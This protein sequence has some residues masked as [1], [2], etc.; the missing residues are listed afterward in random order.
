[1]VAVAVIV[2]M[3]LDRTCSPRQALRLA[4]IPAGTLL[5]AAATPVGPQLYSSFGAIRAVSPYIQEWRIPTLNSPSV[6]AALTMGL[7]TVAIWVGRREPGSWVHISLLGLGFAWGA[8]HMRTVAVGAI[9]VAPV[10]AAALDSA[11]GRPRKLIGRLET[12]VV[13]AGAV[14]SLAISAGLAASGPRDPTGVPSGLSHEL[15]ALPSGTVVYNTD[16]LGGWIMWSHPNL[17]QTRDTRAELYGPARARDYL[18]AMQA[19][20]GWQEI[21]RRTQPGAAL[22]QGDK[23]LVAALRGE[24]W[25]LLGHD[26]GYVLLEPPRE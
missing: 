25:T 26:R 11:L 5:A 20:P 16:V 12:A 10:A 7:L 19:E 2:G 22:V 14:G 13:V 9:L 18:R 1:M 4:A 23:P 15:D 3:L 8:M 24:G 21:V 17:R 6:L